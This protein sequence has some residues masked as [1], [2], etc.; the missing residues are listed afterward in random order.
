M[1]TDVT[2]EPFN[3]LTG[4]SVPVS[5]YPREMFSPFFTPQLVDHIVVETNRYAAVCLTSSHTGEVPESNTNTKEIY[6]YLG[7]SIFMGINRLPHLYD[8][9]STSD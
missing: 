7:L 6:V 5:S 1:L 8:Y 2:V 3:Q 9:W 4:P